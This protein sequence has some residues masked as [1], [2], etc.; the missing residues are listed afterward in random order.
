MFYILKISVVPENIVM[1]AVITIINNEE[2]SFSNT[3]YTEIQKLAHMKLPR[4]HYKAPSL[5]NVHHKMYK[6]F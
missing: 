2:I 4:Y 6:G 3:A 1:K 5:D